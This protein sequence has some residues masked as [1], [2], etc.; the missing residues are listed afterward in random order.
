[1]STHTQYITN[2]LS[3]AA[4]KENTKISRRIVHLINR[5]IFSVVAQGNV[6]WLQAWGSE[7][8][9]PFAIDYSIKRMRGMGFKYLYDYSSEKRLYGGY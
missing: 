2:R 6:F 3:S 1:M 8:I 4:K 7:S 5:N 9:P